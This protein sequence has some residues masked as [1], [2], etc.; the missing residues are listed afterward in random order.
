MEVGSGNVEVGS[1]NAEVGSGN[2]PKADKCGSRKKSIA[3]RA[4]GI[5]QFHINQLNQANKLKKRVS[6]AVQ[7]A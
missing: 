3:Q 6:H 4:Q 7:K 5:R 1:G 2:P